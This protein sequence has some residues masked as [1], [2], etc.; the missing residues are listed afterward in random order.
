MGSDNCLYRRPPR[1]IGTVGL[2][3]HLAPL[4]LTG[5]IK[6]LGGEILVAAALAG[7]LLPVAVAGGVAASYAFLAGGVWFAS[8]LLATFTVH[9]LKARTKAQLSPQWTTVAAPLLGV[10]AIAVGVLASNSP[11]IPRLAALALLPPALATLAVNLIGVHPRRLK[12]V[13]WSLVTANLLTAA[14]L[15]AA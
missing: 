12:R 6:N 11:A 14:L 9:A 10:V 1:G 2:R 7:T 13:G 3:C 8:F 4:A 15:L 5:R